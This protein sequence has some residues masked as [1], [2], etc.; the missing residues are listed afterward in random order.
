MDEGESI[1]Q[2]LELNEGSLVPTALREVP[3]TNPDG[4]EGVDLYLD[5][6]AFPEV[7]A[8]DVPV[9]ADGPCRGSSLPSSA[10]FSAAENDEVKPT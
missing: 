2:L 6:D 10:T 9:N 4:T 8:G 3:F 7:F 1:G 5:Q